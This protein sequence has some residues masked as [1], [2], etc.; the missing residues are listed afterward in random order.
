MSTINHDIVLVEQALAYAIELY[1]ELT[2]ENGAPTLGLQN[3]I[4]DFILADAK[5]C[6]AVGRW[7]GTAEISEA[8]MTPPRRLPYDEA[9]RHIR[10]FVQSRME[11]PVFARPDQEPSDRR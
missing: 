9:Y 8:T 10:S 2:G 3:Q 6:E 5:L 11:P 7:A 1:R 4:V